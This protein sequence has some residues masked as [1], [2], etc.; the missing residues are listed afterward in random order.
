MSSDPETITKLE[1]IE[2]VQEAYEQKKGE[3]K[4]GNVVVNELGHM[5]SLAVDNIED[6][7]S[8]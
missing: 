5:Y 6:G 2:S 3:W 7:G 4:D 1:A 8:Q